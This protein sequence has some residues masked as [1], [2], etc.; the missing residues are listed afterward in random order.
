[1]KSAITISR[2][3]AQA[4]QNDLMI[5]QNEAINNRKGKRIARVSFWRRGLLP[6]GVI[7]TVT[8]LSL[9]PSDGLPKT[10]AFYLLAWLHHCTGCAPDKIAHAGMYFCVC[11]ALLLALPQC[12]FRLR[13]CVVAFV[14]AVGWGA[15]ME[16]LQACTTALGWTTRAFDYYDMLANSVGAAIAVVTFCLLRFVYHRVKWRA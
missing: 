16:I 4:N 11:G 10:E 3:E 14:F 9:A 6:I 13:R 2:N 12:V 8:W 1:V 15:L 5:N 7:G